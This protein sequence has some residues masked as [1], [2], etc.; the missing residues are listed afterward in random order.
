MVRNAFLNQ[1]VADTYDNYYNSPAG[2]QIDRIEKQAI[3]AFLPQPE[4]EP[5]L[6]LGCGT[7]HWS[8]FLSKRGFTVEAL[9]VSDAMLSVAVGKHIPNV[10]FRKGDALNLPFSDESFGTVVSVTML[11]FTND[12]QKVI[13]EVFRVLKPEGL[14]ILGCLNLNSVLGKTRDSDDTFR[15]AHFFT[16][17]ELRT[18][19][20]VFRQVQLTECVYLSDDFTLLDK[21]MDRYPVE[22]AFLAVCAQK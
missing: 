15:H 2:S 17:D 1:A 7:G 21:T 18:Q 9:D 19:L 6:E 3:E 14:L 5:I 20:S 22:G 8:E 4:T 12:P 16:K 13:T 11:E 10:R